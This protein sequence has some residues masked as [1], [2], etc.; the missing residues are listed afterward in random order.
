MTSNA[1][2]AVTQHQAEVVRWEPLIN[3]LVWEELNPYFRTLPKDNIFRVVEI[4]RLTGEALVYLHRVVE[5]M[6]GDGLPYDEKIRGGRV[7][8][9]IRRFFIDLSRKKNGELGLGGVKRNEERER[10]KRRVKRVGFPSFGHDFQPNGSGEYLRCSYDGPVDPGE[11][12]PDQLLMREEAREAVGGAV[13]DLRHGKDWPYSYDGLPYAAYLTLDE[14]DRYAARRAIEEAQD[15]ERSQFYERRQQ[16]IDYLATRLQEFDPGGRRTPLTEPDPPC[17]DLNDLLR[18]QMRI[19]LER[20]LAYEMARQDTPEGQTIHVPG[21]DP[22]EEANTGRR[23][24]VWPRSPRRRRKPPHSKNLAK[25]E[26]ST[27]LSARNL[28]CRVV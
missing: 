6:D 27:G 23:E 24:K 22:A 13:R 25:S 9:R 5:E 11:G 4:E 21:H 14:S 28:A 2:D 10:F 15:V 1:P 17:P 16:T 26:K 7:R 12:R 18:R 3:V 8:H 20:L 19:E